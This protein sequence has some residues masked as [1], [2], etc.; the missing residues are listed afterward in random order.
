MIT[1]VLTASLIASAI[2]VL[3]W[4]PKRIE[5]WDKTM[6]PQDRT[7]FQKAVWALGH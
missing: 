1:R 6:S 7:A 5:H 2:V 4:A 3:L